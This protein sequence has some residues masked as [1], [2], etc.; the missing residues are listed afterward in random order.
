MSNIKGSVKTV[1]ID[2]EG[3]TVILR[4][5]MESGGHQKIPVEM[6]GQQILGVLEIG[7]EVMID[8][9]RIRDRY[10]VMRPPQVRNLTT[11]S[12][13]RVAS[14]GFFSKTGRFLSSL[15]AS[16]TSGVLTAVLVSLVK[17]PLSTIKAVPRSSPGPPGTREALS[18]NP[19]P[20]ILGLVV[21][22]VVFWLVYRRQRRS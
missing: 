22:V 6:R 2:H 13:V 18:G 3:N 20:L 15:A 9:A 8:V 12:V 14:P 10:G 1:R 17:P 5:M 7:D 11:D 21:G 16:I 4:F 19:L